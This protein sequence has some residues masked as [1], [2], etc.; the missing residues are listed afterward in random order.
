VFP[1]MTPFQAFKRLRHW[2][3]QASS[4]ARLGNRRLFRPQL[5]LARLEVRSLL[6]EEMHGLRA[7]EV[8]EWVGT[9]EAKQVLQ[10]LSPFTWDDARPQAISRSYRV[11][12]LSHQGRPAGNLN[13]Q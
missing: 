1:V 9:P 4:R 6:P 12:L 7:V 5:E 2:L 13:G 8:L 3:S 11:A 10:K